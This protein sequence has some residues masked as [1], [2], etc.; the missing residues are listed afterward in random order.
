MVAKTFHFWCI[1][2][3]GLNMTIELI[4]L[5]EPEWRTITT[6]LYSETKIVLM[7]EFMAK[8]NYSIKSDMLLVNPCNSQEISKLR[9]TITS[10]ASLF[11][12]RILGKWNGY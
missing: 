1:A 4:V 6:R 10:Q 12:P 8:S 2:Y 5:I 7:T 3:H 9:R 11:D